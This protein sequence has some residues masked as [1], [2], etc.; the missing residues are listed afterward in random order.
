MIYLPKSS[1]LFLLDYLAFINELK[2]S[3]SKISSWFY[4]FHRYFS[5]LLPCRIFI[6]ISLSEWNVLFLMKPDL[7]IL[8]MIIDFVSSI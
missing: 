7:L 2:K 1:T 3:L 8:F 4:L 5:H 6:N